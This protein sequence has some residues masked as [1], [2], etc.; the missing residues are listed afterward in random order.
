[1]D[2]HVPGA[3]RV[4]LVR[5]PLDSLASHYYFTHGFTHSS[6]HAPAPAHRNV[7]AHVSIQY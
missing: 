6:N 2:A 7:Q 3:W 1:M 4:V 5:D